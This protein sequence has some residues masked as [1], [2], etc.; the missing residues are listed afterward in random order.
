[1]DFKMDIQAT[2]EIFYN[3]YINMVCREHGE[4]GMEVLKEI[5]ESIHLIYQHVEPDNVNGEI[6]IFKTLDNGY[7]PIEN[8]NRL[9][10]YELFSLPQEI[11]TPCIIQVLDNGRYYLWNNLCVDLERLAECSVVYKYVDGSEWFYARKSVSKVKK[12]CSSVS[13]MFSNPT[14]KSL[15]SALEHY[16]I[17]LVRHCTCEILSQAW[18]DSNRIYFK[19]G[20]EIIMRKSLAQFLNSNMRDIEARPEQIVDETH[21]VDIKV[22][23]TFSN[24]LALIE[25]KWLGTP[26]YEDGRIGRPYTDS[27]ARE[28][29]KQLAEYLDANIRLAPDH[30]SRG[31]LVVID[32]RRRN[33]RTYTDRINQENGMFYSCREI[34][35]DPKYHEIRQDFEEP[36]RMF[37][38]P[39]C[40]G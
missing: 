34:S 31:Y 6:V 4:K 26:R 33:I 19:N 12:V 25:I 10:I 20:P 8:D 23:W 30:V 38:E 11:N 27:R 24:R 9:E 18:N 17:K 37:V 2:K 13:S 15:R 16:K 29:A 21:P 14:F 40:D 35:Y 5:L 1:M 22:T 39:V 28:G 7:Y 3:L 32:G 36:I